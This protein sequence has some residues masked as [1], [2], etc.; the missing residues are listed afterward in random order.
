MPPA[1]VHVIP[2]LALAALLAVAFVH[3]PER[4]EATVG[5]SAALLVLTTTDLG[6]AAAAEEIRRL[7]PVVLFLS[8]ILVVA[9]LCAAEGVFV[10][11]G[12]VLSR[13][14]RRSPAGCWR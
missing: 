3:P 11:L 6:D 5:V 1:L 12:A 14:A 10:A 2:L 7:L 8:A 4:L 13:L 9:T